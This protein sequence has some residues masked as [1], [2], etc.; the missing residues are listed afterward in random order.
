M[1]GG[2]NGYELAREA[3]RRRPDLKILL[4]SGYTARA[5]AIVQ[6]EAANEELDRLELLDKPF[7]RRELA[8]RIRQVLDQAS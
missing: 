2:M 6:G 7:R 8:V 5:Q 4:T 1:P 3:R